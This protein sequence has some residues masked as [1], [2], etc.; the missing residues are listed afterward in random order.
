MTKLSIIIANFNTRELTLKCLE[1]IEKEGEGLNYEVIVIDNGSSDGSW[2]ALN[3][4]REKN[5]RL[6]LIRNEENLGY[7]KANNQGIKKSQGKYIFLLNS[8]TYLKP[9]SLE[10]LIEF[11]RS[12]EDAGV[13]GPKL[14][15]HDGSVQASCFRF[16]TVKN[17]IL[18]YWFGKKGLYDKYV[19]DGNNPSEVD[20][21]VGA[22]FLITPKALEKE[23]RLDE[24]Y[25]AYFE[26]IDYCR[27]VHRI[28]LKVYYFPE[29]EVVHYH[30]VSFSKLA[31]KNEQWKRLIPSSKI[32]HGL[33]KHYLINFIL[34]SGQKWRNILRK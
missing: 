26:D 5:K 16:P 31:E 4:L 15:N 28:G 32:Y 25:W 24:R 30:G 27:R 21:L 3:K 6:V 1:S 8:D 17:A 10:K 18:Q 11:A 9:N 34:W 14:L 29:A 12:H 2:E 33:F 22:A 7:V 20:S 19:P 23:E 13:I